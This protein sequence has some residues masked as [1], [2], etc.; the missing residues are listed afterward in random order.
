MYMSTEHKMGIW[1]S[2]DHLY[3]IQFLN[4]LYR[5]CQPQNNQLLKKTA[6]IS[7]WGEEETLACE[8]GPVVDIAQGR[9]VD[10]HEPVQSGDWELIPYPV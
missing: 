4:I 7:Q 10:I 2:I 5:Q 1:Q 6:F 9:G 3:T 8:D